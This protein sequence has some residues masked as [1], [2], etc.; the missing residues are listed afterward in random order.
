[1]LPHCSALLSVFSEDRDWP[2][3]AADDHQAAQ[4]IRIPLNHIWVIVWCVAGVV[5]L[6]ADDLGQQTGVQFFL[7]H[8]GAPTAVLILGGLTSVP[9]AIIGGLIISVGVCVR[10]YLGLLSAAVSRS[11]FAYVLA[12]GSCRSRP[13]GLLKKIIDR[14][15]TDS[16]RRQ[17]P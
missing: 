16:R 6:V 10:V 5:A 11:G 13:R 7:G 12:L 17:K 3:P 15:L 8:G 9:S 14:V 1:V 4:S 2:G